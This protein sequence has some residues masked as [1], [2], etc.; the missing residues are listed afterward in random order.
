MKL[1]AIVVILI[2]YKA[3][4]GLHYVYVAVSSVASV[5]YQ[6][7]YVLTPPLHC[8]LAE[9]MLICSLT[10]RVGKCAHIIDTVTLPYTTLCTW[11]WCRRNP[12]ANH[13]TFSSTTHRTTRLITTFR[14]P[15]AL[16]VIRTTQP[17]LQR[18]L[19]VG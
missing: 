10:V 17:Y 4:M 12:R 2:S 13:V 1:S 18:L 6:Q 8:W 11:L 7:D 3:L 15:V 5:S 16:L 9:E 14:T 19:D